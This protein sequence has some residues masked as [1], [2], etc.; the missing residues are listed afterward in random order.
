MLRS[1]T[2]VI[3]TKKIQ[4]NYCDKLGARQFWTA[5]FISD[6]SE[7]FDKEQLTKGSKYSTM[8][9]ETKIFVISFVAQVTGT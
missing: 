7:R 2:N 9:A 4:A 1:S 5:R 6:Y 3:F 8:A